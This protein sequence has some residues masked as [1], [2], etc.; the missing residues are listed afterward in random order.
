MTESAPPK[1][2]GGN[3]SKKWVWVLGAGLAF[4][5]TQTATLGV[6]RT[7][8]KVRDRID[9]AGPHSGPAAE[10]A[11]GSLAKGERV[12]EGLSALSL[13]AALFLL[14]GRGW[15]LWKI[16]VLGSAGVLGLG[17]WFYLGLSIMD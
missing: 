10:Q 13:A 4:L 17:W 16:P 8:W 2:A 6:Y 7:S 5:V 15:A 3:T 14:V 1:P 11:L 12:L 9:G